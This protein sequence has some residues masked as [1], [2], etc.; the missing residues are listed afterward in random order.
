MNRI[1]RVVELIASQTALLFTLGPAACYAQRS[2]QTPPHIELQSSGARPLH[3]AVRTL[4]HLYGWRITY[5][6][7]P[8]ASR[9]TMS[10]G[11][12]V[13]FLV[14]KGRPYIFST[15]PPG[16]RSLVHERMRI[17][18]DILDQHSSSGNP[19]SFT[20]V[21]NGDFTHII[22]V[23]RTD[24]SRGLVPYSSLLSASV[25]VEP[26]DR[27]VGEIVDLVL[28]QV[29]TIRGVAIVQGLRPAAMYQNEHCVRG[30]D[31]EP[32]E[33]VLATIFELVNNRGISLGASP[34]RVTWD[35]LYDPEGKQFFFSAHVISSIQPIDS[36]RVF[37]QAR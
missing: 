7:P 1:L 32:A 11:T 35:L 12:A 15:V 33:D 4:E 2:Q 23:A 18:R 9:E 25:T 26:K 19:G 34:Q 20:A 10:S 22:P 14:P 29:S 24:E 5:E 3:I 17:I 6:D 21:H 31:N 8:Y 27:T 36:Q 37:E 16:D 13:P 28:R 30:A